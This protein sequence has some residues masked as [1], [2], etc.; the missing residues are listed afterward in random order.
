VCPSS[1][2]GNAKT[3]HLRRRATK[4]YVSATSA[5][6]DALDGPETPPLQSWPQGVDDPTPSEHPPRHCIAPLPALASQHAPRLPT[7]RSQ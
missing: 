4:C 5:I 2:C 1:P 3:R 7:F 6:R